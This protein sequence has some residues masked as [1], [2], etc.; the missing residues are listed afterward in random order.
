LNGSSVSAVISG[1]NSS[2]GVVPPVP[3]QIGSTLSGATSYAG[4]TVNVASSVT[5]GGP[6]AGS[7]GQVII[8]YDLGTAEAPEPSTYALMASGLLGFGLLR[9]RAARRR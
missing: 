8:S 2:T 4:F 6:V 1:G 7:S 3:F 9:L 5:A